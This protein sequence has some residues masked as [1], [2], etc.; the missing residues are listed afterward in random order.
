MGSEWCFPFIFWAARRVGG[1]VS[2]RLDWFTG[3]DIEPAGKPLTIG[4]LT[5]ES[6][7]PL[8]DHDAIGLDFRIIADAR[9]K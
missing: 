5:D 6:G 9:T 3:R 7:T 4:N 1:R 2:G 8:S